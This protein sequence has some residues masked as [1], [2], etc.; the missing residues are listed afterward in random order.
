MNDGQLSQPEAKCEPPAN[1]CG[2]CGFSLKLI[3]PICQSRM[4][5][6]CDRRIYF[7]RHAPEGGFRVE[8]GEQFHIT[9]LKLSLDPME[10]GKKSHFSRAGLDSF[11]RHIITDGGLK[12]HE[13]FISYCKEKERQ[14]DEELSR[15][16]YINHLDLY[17]EKDVNEAFEILKREG[18]NEYSN[19]LIT[20]SFFH[21]VH[22]KLDEGDSEGAARAAF[23][24]ALFINLQILENEHYKEI[25][26]L[27]YQAYADLRQNEGLNP[28]E[29][30][31]KLVVEQVARK[32]KSLSDPYLLSLSQ[33]DDPLSV[34]LG[35]NGV[36]ENGL[37]A[38]VQHE[39]ERRK[40]ATE[41][42]LRNREVTVKERESKLKMLGLVVTV[43]N[44]LIGV[45]VTL[46]LKN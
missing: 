19:Q 24:A 42:E 2:A 7:Q 10:G 3:N 30:R 20:S 34:P 29:A 23:R 9:E 38:L 35:V 6:K 39:L 4:C 17:N 25:I 16:E 33:S 36:R 44:V 46:F 22:T 15:L 14:L 5:Q 21:E 31:E 18:A 11:L 45:G 26:W 12:R 28:D 1:F 8:E 13:E 43:I 27:G 37:R 40:R 41:E 32:L